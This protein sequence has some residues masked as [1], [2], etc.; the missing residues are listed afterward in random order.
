[1]AEK[2]E[3]SQSGSVGDEGGNL[4]DMLKN[5]ELRDDELDDVVIGPAAVEEYRKDARWMAIGKVLTSRSFSAEALFEKM[6]A[7]W[8]KTCGPAAA[9][10]NFTSIRMILLA[11]DERYKNRVQQG[12]TCWTHM[13]GPCDT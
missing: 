12:A 3:A 7:I 13:T 6:K 10:F 9:S 1:M 2:G 5:L 4:D 11:C 8:E